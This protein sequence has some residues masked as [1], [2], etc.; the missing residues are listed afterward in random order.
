MDVGT[1]R[2]WY[3]L[4]VSEDSFYASH[5]TPTQPADSVDR[6]DWP[7]GYKAVTLSASK[8][9]WQRWHRHEPEYE[10][11]I[12]EEGQEEEHEAIETYRAWLLKAETHLVAKAAQLHGRLDEE[13]PSNAGGRYGP[14]ADLAAMSDAMKASSENQVAMMREAI[15]DRQSQRQDQAVE[16]QKQRVHE[17]QEQA[18]KHQEQMAMIRAMTGQR[19]DPTPASAPAAPASKGPIDRCQGYTTMSLMD[20]LEAADASDCLDLLTEQKMTPARM[21]RV[22]SKH[23]S[24]AELIRRLEAMGVA[25]GDA[26]SI[27]DEFY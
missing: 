19:P 20:L 18:E 12:H 11:F 6:Q 9:E 5:P 3:A 17:R 27:V 16:N 15:E 1:Q 24:P 26:S 2:A 7:E 22:L 13:Q 23:P 21:Y 8:V 14:T 25:A 10:Q 4:D